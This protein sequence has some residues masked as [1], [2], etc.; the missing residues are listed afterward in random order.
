MKTEIEYDFKL[1]CCNCGS[2]LPTHRFLNGDWYCPECYKEVTK[3]ERKERTN[4]RITIK[5]NTCSLGE[6]QINHTT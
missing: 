1:R 4:E 2:D 3:L 5:T 6:R